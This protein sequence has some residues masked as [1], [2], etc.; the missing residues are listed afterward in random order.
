MNKVLLIRSSIFGRDSKSIRL[1]N[2]F[3]SRYPHASLVERVLSPTTMPHLMAETYVAMGKPDSELT[4]EERAHV[5]LSD[6]LVAEVKAADT[7]V[8][9]VPMYNLSIPSTLKA[10]IDHVAR[11]GKTFIYTAA[12][13]QGLLSGKKVFVL[14]ARGGVYSDGPAQP[15]D[16]QTPYLRGVLG[17][18]GIMDVTFIHF[19]GANI[20]AEA[21]AT[22]FSK[23]QR[24]ID[25][26]LSRA[27]VE[28]QPDHPAIAS[29]RTD[30]VLPPLVLA[31]AA[32]Q[33]GLRPS[34]HVDL[35]RDLGCAGD[36]SAAP[37]RRPG[38]ETRVH[39]NGR[40]P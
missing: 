24:T 25:E 40:L 13:P 30:H 32:N 29:A 35:P 1:A 14:T 19:E 36:N 38:T 31:Q 3:L 15:L 26:V 6:A 18:L 27:A 34:T 4:G 23:A 11:L 33:A 16:F 17:F 8:L 12:G 2:E 28:R 37:W 10:W 5:A 39:S 22:G 20:S 9:A 21:A 7:I